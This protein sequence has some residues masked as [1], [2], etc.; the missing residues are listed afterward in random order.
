LAISCWSEG[1]S[2]CAPRRSV[3]LSTRP[4]KRALDALADVAQAAELSAAQSA[5]QL[6]LSASLTI[7]EFLL[8]S[9]LARFRLHRPDIH[10]QLEVVNS[11]GVIVALRERRAEIGFVEGLEPVSDWEAMPIARDQLLVVVS[12][13]HPWARRRSVRPA[14]LASQPYLTRERRSGTR[15][16]A[17][18][19]P[20]RLGVTLTPALEAASLQSL[21]RAIR[22]GGFT[23]ISELTIEAEQRAGVLTGLPVRGVDL[24]RDLQAIR[25]RRSRPSDAASSFWRWL[26]R[27]TSASS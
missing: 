3:A 14:E 25:G 20:R 1:D 2:A 8:P 17:D 15:A 21:K 7:G 16:V 11:S 26:T 10:P 22:D 6:R 5:K 27:E 9:W 4:A 18:A 12:A 24:D 13:D 23:L 19:A